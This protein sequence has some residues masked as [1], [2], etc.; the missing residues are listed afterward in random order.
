MYRLL[1]TIL[2]FGFTGTL[3]Y[4][5]TS[6]ET[7][8]ANRMETMRKALLKPDKATLENIAADALT[9]GHSTGLIENKAAFVQD[10]VSGK[11]VF[12]EVNFLEQTIKV[13]GNIAW[14]R[15]RMTGATN[16]NNVPAKVDI[17]VM[18]VWQKRKGE[19]KLFARQAAKLT[20]PAK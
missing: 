17:I 15:N 11:T 3:L 20:P 6:D 10:L 2:L 9:Y 5:Q 13:S 1:L 8:I 7:A 16:N 19:W 18:L 14:V 12:T 4:A